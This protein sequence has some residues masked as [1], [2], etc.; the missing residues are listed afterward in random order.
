MI[1]L[2]TKELTLPKYRRLEVTVKM[3]GLFKKSNI[4]K[5]ERNEDLPLTHDGM[6]DSYR[7]NGLC[8]R[9]GKQ[10]SFETIG[11]LPVTF[12]GGMVHPSNGGPPYPSCSDKVICMVCRHCHQ[13]M[14]VVEEEWIDDHPSR[15]GIGKGGEVSFRGI[16]WW[17]LPQS[18]LSDDIPVEISNIYAEAELIK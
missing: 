17:P 18:K 8:P 11:E 2:I 3:F 4:L 15:L 10:S 13:G 16:P 12:N 1:L 14:V 6:P 9:C 5:G 7:P